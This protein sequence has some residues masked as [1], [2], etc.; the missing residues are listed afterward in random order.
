MT[1]P[2]DERVKMNQPKKLRNKTASSF[3]LPSVILWLARIAAF[4]PILGLSARMKNV[5]E[6][7][8]H[9]I[10]ATG[11]NRTYKIIF[12]KRNQPETNPKSQSFSIFSGT[13]SVSSFFPT[14]PFQDKSSRVSSALCLKLKNKAPK[15]K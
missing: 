5:C 6:Y 11:K 4:T 15:K 12:A 1:I 8:I 10:I 9:L 3:F 14:L 7:S 13:A 2:N